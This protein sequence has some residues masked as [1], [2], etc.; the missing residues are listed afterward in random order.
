[1]GII[2]DLWEVQK[3]PQKK[4][5]GIGY[6]SEYLSNDDKNTLSYKLWH[7]MIAKCFGVGESYDRDRKGKKYE[8]CNSWLDYQKFLKWF[9]Q[10]YKECGR[11]DMLLTKCIISNDNTM[12]N[13]NNCAIVPKDIYRYLEY[14]NPNIDK[15]RELAEKYKDCIMDD[16]YEFLM[17]E[18]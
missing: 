9:K 4:I 13:S 1:M 5:L 16:I 8:C 7:R 3:E 10:N 15:S 11:N 6:S 14:E 12:Y 2:Y 17:E 18:Y